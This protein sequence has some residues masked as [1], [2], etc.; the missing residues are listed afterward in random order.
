M[1]ESSTRAPIV[2]THET[3]LS[4]A[5]QI[6]GHRVLTDQSERAGGA[7]RAPSPTLTPPPPPPPAGVAA[8]VSGHKPSHSR[9]DS[10]ITNANANTNTNTATREIGAGAGAQSS[11][12]PAT[13]RYAHLVE[14]GMTDAE[15]RRL[16]EEERHLD[17]AIEDAG[18][19]RRTSS[20]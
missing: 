11:T 17:E 10:S 13:S 9:S 16:E 4:F 6:R 14:E 12:P 19:H 15:I 5:A 1:A 3:G 18:R 20:R 2:V 8:V 7:D